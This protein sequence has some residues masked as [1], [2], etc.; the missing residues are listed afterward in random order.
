MILQSTIPQ[1]TALNSIAVAYAVVL[2]AI[3]IFISLMIGRQKKLERK[4]QA[5]K[6]EMRD[7]SRK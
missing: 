5:L 6:D 4:L 3:F 2:G 1:T 7:A